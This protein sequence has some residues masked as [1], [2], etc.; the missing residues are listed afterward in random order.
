MKYS[1]PRR[2]GIRR[3]A[4][5]P[6]TVLLA[7]T[8]GCESQPSATDGPPAVVATSTI[9]A[10]MAETVGGDAIEVISLLSPGDD[11][12]VYEPVPQDS[13]AIEQ[14]DLIF[15]NGYD[16][17]PE[18]I[19][20]IEGAGS[21]ENAI[22]IG[23][24]VEPLDFEEDGQ[25]VP[26]PHV[27]GSAEN[28]IVMVEAIR[29]TLIER[30]PEDAD[31]IEANADA[32]IAELQELHDWIGEQIQ[33]IPAD[34]RQLVTTHDAFQYYAVAYD[35]EIIGTLIGVSTEE[36]PSAQTVSR[37]V[38][39]VQAAN[40]PAIFAETTLNPALIETV[41]QEAGVAL[42]DEELY[43]DALGE[44]GSGADT[45]ST[46]LATNTRIIVEALG[47]NYSPWE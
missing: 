25:I 9:L 18:L 4:I 44:P 7:L 12:H 20:L 38:E 40:V 46:M 11:P 30:L 28:G 29:D 15:Y 22:A 19:R 17:E 42:A 35:L 33:T 16:L 37:L 36:Q 41:A 43:S 34:Q 14:A 21:G 13:V 26:D 24:V 32:L 39:A 47:G 3:G 2:G 6:L 23:E 5:A 31:Q 27:W 10:D 1:F 8:A 45:Y